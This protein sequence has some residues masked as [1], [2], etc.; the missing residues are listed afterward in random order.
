[1]GSGF[2][3]FQFNWIN[4][5]SKKQIEKEIS[6]LKSEAIF[7]QALNSPSGSALQYDFLNQA[8]FTRLVEKGELKSDKVGSHLLK[9]SGIQGEVRHFML[10]I[11]A[12]RYA[13]KQDTSTEEII[14]RA[15]AIFDKISENT[16]E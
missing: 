11:E 15:R 5:L 9:S 1:M 2:L 10:D 6:G 7:S 13:G 3:I 14:E 16:D 12:M 8:L 4:F